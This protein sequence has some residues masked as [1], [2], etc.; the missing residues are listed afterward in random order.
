VTLPVATIDEAKD[1]PDMI[2][3]PDNSPSTTLTMA[4]AQELKELFLNN[5]FEDQMAMAFSKREASRK[6]VHK[7]LSSCPSLAA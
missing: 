3:S 4:E 1:M 7:R 2:V 5:R 6:G